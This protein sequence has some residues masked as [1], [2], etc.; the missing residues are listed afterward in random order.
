MALD[1][2]GSLDRFKLAGVIA[3]WW[4]ETLPDLKT[5]VENDFSGVIDGW[6][7][8][9]G[10]ALEDDEASGP[11][12]DPF[13]HKLVR[14][15]MADYLDQMASARANM[16]RLRGE[17][18]AFEQRNQP[19]GVDEEEL[20]K[21]SF[22]KDVERQIRELKATHRDELK[23]LGRLNRSASKGAAKEEARLAANHATARLRPILTELE[24]LERVVAPYEQIKKDVADAR[25]RY[26]EL[27]ADFV[28]ELKRRTAMLTSNQKC[29][30]VVDLFSRDVQ[31][32]LEG[33]MAEKRE[34]AV[35]VIE[36]LQRKYCNSLST[37][38]SRREQISADFLAALR[39]LGY[40]H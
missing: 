13:A 37:L 9:I 16:A 33:A 8:A 26:R 6:V 17:R 21:W 5:L 27:T 28:G 40:D 12:F 22:A 35:D 32:S 29:S 38:I 18:E 1:P 19:E 36:V 15:V 25:A 11:S 39:G 31:A 30:L 24:A 23:E 2:L 10:D 14:S 20:E 3:T 7:D 4:S 34:A